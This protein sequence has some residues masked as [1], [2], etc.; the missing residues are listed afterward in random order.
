MDFDVKVIEQ[1]FPDEEQQKV[2]LKLF[3]YAEDSAERKLQQ[4]ME[5][6]G[7]DPSIFS[8]DKRSKAINQYRR[9]YD[10]MD[11]VWRNS[12]RPDEFSDAMTFDQYFG[13]DQDIH[14]RM[15]KDGVFTSTDIGMLTPRVIE[16]RVREAIEPALNLTPLYQRIS[17]PGRGTQ[18]VFPSTGGIEAADIGEAE[19]YPA[20]KMEFAGS[21]AATIG[22][23]GVAIQITEEAIRYSMFDVVNMHVR[24]AGRALARLKEYK[25]ADQLLTNGT[26]L[27]NNNSSSVKSTTGRDA[28]GAYNGTMTVYDFLYAWSQLYNTNG[29]TPNTIIMNPFGW[30]VFAQDPLMRQFF[31][32]NGGG[33]LIQLPQGAPGRATQWNLGGLHNSQNVTDPKAIATSY[34]EPPDLW[35]GSVRI[36]VSPFVPYNATTGETDLILC[37]SSEVGVLVEDESVAMDRWEDPAR[38]IR[39][40]KFRERYG[41]ATMNNGRAIGYIKGVSIARGYDFSDKITISYDPGGFSGDTAGSLTLD[42]HFSPASYSGQP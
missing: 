38:D 41:F 14:D 34:A 16:E 30:L 24:A 8:M 17:F 20:R 28:A 12:G 5:E 25:A 36:I 26:V 6:A 7:V 31:M 3:K 39:H 13:M 11:K 33:Q 19:E 21:V 29:Y 22:K 32:Q 23:S 4:R 10:L 35:P 18:I 2:V 27:L 15:M 40:M 42:D 9:A 37:D 1:A